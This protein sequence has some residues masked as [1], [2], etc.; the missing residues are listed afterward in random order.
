MLGA[1]CKFRNIAFIF[2][3]L[4]TK[5]TFSS[6]I[7]YVRMLVKLYMNSLQVISERAQIVIREM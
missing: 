5:E 2:L 3:V 1:A 7:S 6:L 4:N